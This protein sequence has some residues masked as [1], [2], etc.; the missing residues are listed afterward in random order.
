MTT[1]A[2]QF[3]V[4]S[5]EVLDAAG[6]RVFYRF[7]RIRRN[8]GLSDDLFRFEPEP[9]TEISGSHGP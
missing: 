1:T 4:E 8:R 9:G 5:A 3:A 2:P 6:N 7:F